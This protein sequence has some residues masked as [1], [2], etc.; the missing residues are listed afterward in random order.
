MV[1]WPATAMC[2]LANKS[3]PIQNPEQPR[4]YSLQASRLINRL[5]YCNARILLNRIPCVFMRNWSVNGRRA[6]KGRFWRM[7]SVLRP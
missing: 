6:V 2:R 3:W 4:F 7:P 5:R 1:S